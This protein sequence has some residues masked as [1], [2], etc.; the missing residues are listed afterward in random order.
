MGVAFSDV[1]ELTENTFAINSTSRKAG[2][3][4]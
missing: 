3:I 1:C 4:V 2:R